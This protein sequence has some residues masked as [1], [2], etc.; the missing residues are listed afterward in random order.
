MTG[1]ITIPL[2]GGLGNM[3][4]QIS[5]AYSTSIRDDKK[6]I[7]DNISNMSPHNPPSHYLS[8]IFRKIKFEDLNYHTTIFSE[9]GFHF[10]EIPKIHGNVKLSGFFQSEKYFIDHREQLLNLF[11]IDLPTKEK[12]YLKYSNELNLETC[13]IHVRRGDYVNIQEYHNLLSLDYYINSVN[14]IGDDNHYLI[15]S[16]DI[17]WCEKN[18]SF[19]KNKTF[20]K[21]NTDYE[22]LYLMSLCNNN[23][24]ANSTFSWWGAWLNTNEN[25]KVISPKQWFGPRYSSYITKDLYCKNWIVL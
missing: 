9:N 17:D 3:L 20:I 5:A 11:E 19:I 14:I 4:F 2:V 8:T 16:D 13:S 21:G 7:C 12:L 24:I 6:F 25:K 22:D 15:F 10:N 23:I 18:L 1:I